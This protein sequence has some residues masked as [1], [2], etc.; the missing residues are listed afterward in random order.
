M[1]HLRFIDIRVMNVFLTLRRKARDKNTGRLER[2]AKGTFDMS[3][4]TTVEDNERSTAIHKA[5]RLIKV[6]Y[7]LAKN[8]RY[9]RSIFCKGVV[10]SFEEA[11]A[12]PPEG[13][14]RGCSTG[15]SC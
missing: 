1:F 5:T 6:I 2:T 10:V 8:F 13:R 11:T 15:M 12:A 9:C 14:G 7:R 4:E 3:P